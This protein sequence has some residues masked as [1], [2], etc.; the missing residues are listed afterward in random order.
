MSVIFRCNKEGCETRQGLSDRDYRLPDGWFLVQ[1]DED[2]D[3]HF[4]SRDCLMFWAAQSQLG[5][6][7]GALWDEAWDR[8]EPKFT[9]PITQ[10]G[11]AI[12]RQLEAYNQGLKHSLGESW[13]MP[14]DPMMEDNGN[15]E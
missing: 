3:Y 13:P 1:D 10:Y 4:C 11:T 14:E 9:P 8:T 6:V 2:D 5:V 12:H 15:H 7:E